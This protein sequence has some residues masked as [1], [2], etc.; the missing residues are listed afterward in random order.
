MG[1]VGGKVVTGKFAVHVGE[2]QIHIRELLEEA[3]QTFLL[4][5]GDIAL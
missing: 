5:P 1:V 3:A 2:P 4:V